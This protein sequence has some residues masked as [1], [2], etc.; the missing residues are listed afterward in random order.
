MY[1]QIEISVVMRTG[2]VR[3]NI[4]CSAFFFDEIEWK[5]QHLEIYDFISFIKGAVYFEIIHDQFLT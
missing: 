3:P 1:S 2:R 5:I 4:F